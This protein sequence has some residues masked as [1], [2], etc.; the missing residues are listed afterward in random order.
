MELLLEPLE[1]GGE[2][3]RGTVL[4]KC[5]DSLRTR[6]LMF[7]LCFFVIFVAPWTWLNATHSRAV[8][9]FRFVQKNKNGTG[10]EF[11]LIFQAIWDTSGAQWH[12]FGIHGAARDTAGTGTEIE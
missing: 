2:I 12:H 9:D 6:F 8:F 3:L 11:S 7:V 5:G 4:K 10:S 1:T